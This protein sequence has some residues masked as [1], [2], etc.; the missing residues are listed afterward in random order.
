MERVWNQPV[1]SNWSINPFTLTKDALFD[2][3][4]DALPAH[5]KVGLRLLNGSPIFSR[6]QPPYFC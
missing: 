2:E 4:M 5:P 3:L 1:I 6:N